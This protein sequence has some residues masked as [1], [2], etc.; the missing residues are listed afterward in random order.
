M[1]LTPSRGFAINMTNYHVLP[2][3]SITY[4]IEETYPNILY[5]YL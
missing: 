1:K 2:I 5:H 3:F 4:C